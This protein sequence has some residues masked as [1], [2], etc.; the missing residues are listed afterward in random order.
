MQLLCIHYRTVHC[1]LFKIYMCLLPT[2]PY[3]FSWQKYVDKGP[4]YLCW[5]LD[6]GPFNTWLI[7][8]WEE[9]LCCYKLN[10][11]VT[12]WQ[13]HIWLK[14]VEVVWVKIHVILSV[15]QLLTTFT[16]LKISHM[17]NGPTAKNLHRCR[18]PKVDDAVY[19]IIALS[20]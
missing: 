20:P 19:R 7:S 2:Y 1:G 8:S 15:S 18:G 14:M 17:L 4:L 6:V 9:N 5:F 12:K 16:Q 11:A 10:K 13:L 3:S